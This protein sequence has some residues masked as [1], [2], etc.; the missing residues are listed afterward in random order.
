VSVY[1]S[2]KSAPYYWFDFQLNGRRFY[3]STE[4]KTRR[5]AEKFEALERDRAKVLNK[6][7]KRSKTS[8]LIDD[9]ASRLWNDE[10][11]YDAAPDATSKNIARLVEYF[12]KAKP[13]TD[14]DHNEV[15][16]LVAW[17]RGH[18]IKGREKA[19]LISNATVNRSAT[20]VLQRIFT[21]A[22][23]GGAQF[24]RE[25]DW[26]DLLLP[27]PVE[28]VREL[29]DDEA[30]ALADATRDDYEPFFDFVRASGLRQAEC[31]TLKWP[32]VNFGTRQIVR[33]GKGGRR[34]VF[35]ITDTIWEILFPLQGQHPEYVFTYVAVYGNKRLGR[36]RGQRYRLTINGA[37]SAWQ[38]M[39]AKSGVKDFRFHDYR[40]DFGTKLLRD[41]GNLKLVQKAMNHRDIKS[42]LRYA[43][44]LD[45]DV[46]AAVE[47]VAKSRG[48]SRGEKLKAS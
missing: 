4:C 46:A 1:R 41:S 25:P 7:M 18:R 16:K 45:E 38:R 44:V 28:R 39:R 2:K 43:H 29:H 22:K 8:L 40:H 23:A 10:A 47:R 31:V 24:E 17:R 36:V 19:P 6:A 3:G 48:K 32:E 26:T 27:E 14:I 15:K 9:V 21:F 42:T 5:E 12:G 30:V 11:Q 34:V 37:K 33:L 13:L 20:K 35:P